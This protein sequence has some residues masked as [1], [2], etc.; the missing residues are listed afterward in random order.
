MGH[1]IT[2]GPFDFQS[3]ENHNNM[4]ANGVHSNIVFCVQQKK[5]TDMV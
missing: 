1:Q 3:M 2:Q 4:E 5:E